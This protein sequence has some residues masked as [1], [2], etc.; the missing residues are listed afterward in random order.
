MSILGGYW[1][2]VCFENDF[3]YPIEKLIKMCTNAFC[4]LFNETR[5]VSLKKCNLF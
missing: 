5:S 1:D 3:F 2:T 4:N